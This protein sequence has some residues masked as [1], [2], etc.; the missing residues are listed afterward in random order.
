M[1]NKTKF[2][3]EA[4]SN[5]FVITYES[6]GSHEVSVAKTNEDIKNY[7]GEIFCNT[8]HL[9]KPGKGADIVFEVL[10]TQNNDSK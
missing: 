7:F 5:G 6:K 3:I 10:K 2:H 1:N 4:A 9:I 8:L